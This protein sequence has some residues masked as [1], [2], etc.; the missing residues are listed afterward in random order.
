[1]KAK[2]EFD[3]S[4]AEDI[5]A[6]NNANNASNMRNFLHEIYDTVFRPVL[7]YGVMKNEE[8]SNLEIEAVQHIWDKL[9]NLA[10]EYEVKL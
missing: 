10:D 4:D 3:L 8:V 7:K 2:L 5:L 9:Q 6:Y 1:M